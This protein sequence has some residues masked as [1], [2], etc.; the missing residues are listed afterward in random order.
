M[1]LSNDYLHIPFSYIVLPVGIGLI[2]WIAFLSG[3]IINSICYLFIRIMYYEQICPDYR[4]EQLL[5]TLNYIKAIAL[6]DD[7]PSESKTDN[8]NRFVSRL[9]SIC[10]W[11]FNIVLIAKIMS[12]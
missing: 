5:H 12:L 1:F 9:F 6:F 11:I 2:I 4:K 8:I 7:L 10:F 3:F